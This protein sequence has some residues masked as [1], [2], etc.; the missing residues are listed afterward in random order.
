[1]PFGLPCLPP[2]P[3]WRLII[4]VLADLALPSTII[5]CCVGSHCHSDHSNLNNRRHCHSDQF[6]YCIGGMHCHSQNIILRIVRSDGRNIGVL[7]FILTTV[8]VPSIA[9][10]GCMSD[11]L[12]PTKN[13]F[14]T[15]RG[16]RG[17][18]MLCWTFSGLF[19]S[20]RSAVDLPS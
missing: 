15:F 6:D 11:A 17:Y 12:Y 20:C 4:V 9:D 5:D 8:K 7:V 18:R 1:M 2:I 14:K 10:L 16:P 3:M 19:W 13:V